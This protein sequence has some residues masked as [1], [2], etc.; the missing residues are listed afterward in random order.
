[1]CGTSSAGFSKSLGHAGEDHDPLVAIIFP[2][3]SSLDASMDAHLNCIECG[4]C[5]AGF[6]TSH[7]TWV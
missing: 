6:S 1:M 2:V 7:S 5:V 4:F 3:G